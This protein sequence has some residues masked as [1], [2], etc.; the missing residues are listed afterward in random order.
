MISIVIPIYNEEE[1]ID[2]LY[3]RLTAASPSWNDD[4]E[5]VLVD[6]ACLC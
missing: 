4:Y 2:L 1:N 3:N 5:V 6:D